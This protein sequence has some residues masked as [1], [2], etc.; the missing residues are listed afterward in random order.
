MKKRFWRAARPPLSRFYLTLIVLVILVA[1]GIRPASASGPSP[2]VGPYPYV[3]GEI[4]IGW[5]PGNGAVPQGAAPK[6]FSTDRTGADWQKTA[7]TLEARTGLTVLSAEPY[8]GTARLAAPPG[9]EQVEIARLSALPWIEYAEP[10]YIAYAADTYPGD[11]D[12]GR[13]W[14]MRRIYAP[15]A[16]DLT[17][18]S[19]SIV[20]A[21]VD[22]GI[23]SGHPEFAQR[24]LPG[25][26]YVE[27]DY[28]PD[29]QF[30]HG[31]HVSGI[32]AAAANNGL[33]VAGL[34]ADVNILPLKVL[35]STG[36]GTSDNVATAIRRAADNSAQIINLSLQVLG[37]SITLHNAVIYAAGDKGS[38]VVAAAGNYGNVGNPEVYPAAYPEAFTVAASTHDDEWASYSGYNDHVDLAAPG[39]TLS[40][41]IWSTVLMSQ[42]SYGYDFGTS[43]ATPLVSAAAALVWTYRPAAPTLEVTGILK[44]AADK[45][46]VFPYVNGRNQHFGY[47]RLNVGKAVRLAYPP[48]L[49]AS[50]SGARSFLLGGPI[51]QANGTVSLI[52]PSEQPVTW[53]ASVSPGA[54]WLKL[55]S[56]SGTASFSAPGDLWL[57]VGPTALPPGSYAGLIQVQYDIPPHK[58]DI[59]VQLEL[60]G[61]LYRS[62]A[63]QAMNNYLGANWYDPL[64]GGQALGLSD[65]SLAQVSLPFLVSFYGQVY[66]SI[67]V[68]DNGVALF[69]L[70][71]PAGVFNPANCMPS[72]AR[73]NDA[74]YVL[75]DDWV[76][77][78][79]GQVYVDQPDNNTLVIS[80][81]QVRR[82]GSPV[83]HSFQLVLTRD[84]RVLYQ[85]QTVGSP[86]EGTIGIENF[87]GTLA[88][89]ILC[90]GVGHQVRDGD[91]LL[92]KPVVPW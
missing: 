65:N 3:P 73:P 62:F 47:G 28:L 57:Q 60:A 58:F 44:Q 71:A 27:N 68:S 19:Y 63:P 85:Y 64:P 52:N 84:G 55:S 86:L 46:G 70:P 4:L 81:Y 16:W 13:Q 38:L 90:N 32:L 30:G 23:D 20:V 6:G 40:D 59:P 11:P 66:S 7:Q 88:Q 9:Q 5:Q 79:G 14:N 22:S 35:D 72:A 24:I 37:D 75:W 91:A 12:I 92:M 80:W 1:A 49:S 41:P 45:V 33:G 89:Q 25:W 26:D 51:Q 82:S 69:T 18:G 2:V 56:S 78:L 29:D 31:T 17:M 10:N 21:V 77:E 39:G 76:P 42:G 15:A 48:S 36:V 34:A 87:D 83:P 8:Y 43:M 54:D 61:T 53:Q 74:F 67:W 50:P